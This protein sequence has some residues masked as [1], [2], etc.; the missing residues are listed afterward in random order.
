MELSRDD[1]F[2]L[3][4]SY[5]NTIKLNTMLL[6]QHKQLIEDQNKILTKQ[7]ESTTK[8]STI[9]EGIETI[10]STLSD[11]LQEIR[12]RKNDIEQVKDVIQ[13]KMNDYH[14][15]NVKHFGS[16]KLGMNITY[17]AIASLVVSLIGLTY[18][19]FTK[20]EL[21]EKISHALGV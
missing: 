9:F 10:G 17:V 8:L 2:L 6:E 3:M 13:E 20:L 1:L 16:I 19:V 14:V 4:Q 5:E 7:I 18:T 21:L 11:S 15:E 12:E